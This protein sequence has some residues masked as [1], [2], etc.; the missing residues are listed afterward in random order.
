MEVGGQHHAP[1]TLAPE[2]DTASIVHVQEVGWTPGL[3][4]TGSENLLPLS[5]IDPC[6]VQPVASLY[7]LRHPCPRHPKLFQFCI[8]FNT[9]TEFCICNK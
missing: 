8:L 6:T 2:N 3:V 5:G 4:W 7:R 1:A 9:H